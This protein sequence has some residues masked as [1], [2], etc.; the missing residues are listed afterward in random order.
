MPKP[1]ASKQSAPQEQVPVP[2]VE[3][4]EHPP[5][6]QP[7]KTKEQKQKSS[8]PVKEVVATPP[9][10]APV[11]EVAP[12]APVVQ[13]G[14]KKQSKQAKKPKVEE[15][16]VVTEPVQEVAAPQKS[17][18]EAVVSSSATL[19]HPVSTEHLV[20]KV[21]TLISLCAE[22]SRELKTLDKSHIKE[23]KLLQKSGMKRRKHMGKP[24]SGFVKCATISDEMATFLG[25]PSGSLM[26]R[27]D[28]TKAIH[29][30]VKEQ[31]LQLPK[32]R[33]VIMADEKLRVLLKIPQEEVDSHNFTYFKL[34]KYLKIHFPKPAVVEVTPVA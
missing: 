13:E 31:N 19:E 8:A 16:A 10:P 15:V 11:A 28:V 3:T 33:R 27:T 30:Y 29:T 6:S 5:V 18:E 7:K 25:K 22:L 20:S 34:Q 17:V 32:N 21:K 4:S 14:G 2:V 23:L 1:S 12:P 26:S 24:P 9:V